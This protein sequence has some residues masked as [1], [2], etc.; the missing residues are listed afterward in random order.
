M[1]FCLSENVWHENG[2]TLLGRL[3]IYWWWPDRKW[4]LTAYRFWI[5]GERRGDL[6]NQTNYMAFVAGPFQVEWWMGA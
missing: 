2:V 4:R 3:K 5:G 1:Y 6:K